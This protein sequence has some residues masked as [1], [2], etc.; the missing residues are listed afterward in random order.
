MLSLREKLVRSIFKM[1]RYTSRKPRVP[2]L[3]TGKDTNHI[4]T[5]SLVP[6]H[7]PKLPLSLF[8]P[9]SLM[10]FHDYHI[11]QL[12]SSLIFIGLDLLEEISPCE[13]LRA[14]AQRGVVNAPSPHIHR[15]APRV[16]SL[17]GSLPTFLAVYLYL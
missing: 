16:Y 10:P 14:Q 6:G 13:A 5:V 7:K 12:P 4:R 17:F 11:I 2:Q 8:H 1:L 3:T 15:S 9:P